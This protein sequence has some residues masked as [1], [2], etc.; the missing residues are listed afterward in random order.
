MVM[1]KNFIYLY[2]QK[3]YF[4][5]SQI[6]EGITEY[7]VNE[8]ASLNENTENQKGKIFSGKVLAEFV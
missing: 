5:S 1:I 3:M 4:L 7:V 2:E 6:F 8:S